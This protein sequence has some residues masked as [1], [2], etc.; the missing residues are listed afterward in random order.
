MVDPARCVEG[1][2]TSSLTSVDDVVLCTVVESVSTGNGSP[3]NELEMGRD[4]WD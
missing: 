4:V 2:G 1:F 3:E